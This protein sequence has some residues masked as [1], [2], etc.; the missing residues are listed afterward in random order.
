MN[1]LRKRLFLSDDLKSIYDTQLFKSTPITIIWFDENIDEDLNDQLQNIHDHIFI[2]TD[3]STF[4]DYIQTMV[5]EAI[6]VLSGA[7]S[8]T[9]IPIIHDNKQ[10]NS[11]YI[12]CIQ[13]S[14]YKYLCDIYSKIDSIHTEYNLL[15]ESLEKN[16][17]LIMKQQISLNLFDQS[18]QSTQDLTRESSEFLWY[19]LLREYIMKMI[20]T[21]DTKKI[22]LEKFRLYYRTNKPY[23]S[24]IDE[25]EQTYTTNDAIKWY[26]KGTFLFK[27]VNQALRTQDIEALLAVRYYVVDLCKCLKE[28]C[29]NFRDYYEDVIQVYRGQT[30]SDLE[31]DRLKNSIGQLISTNGF[32]STTRSLDIA[33][34]FATNTIFIINVKTQLEGVVFADVRFHS[35]TPHEE[36]ILFDLGTIF[37]IL[38][39]E[40]DD[41]KKLY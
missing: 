40:Y 28:E 8:Q 18:G 7:I 31:L 15:F 24:K 14:K 9:I 2:T 4:L 6:V 39:V 35:E 34:L 5:N 3:R 22:M 20:Q 12:F 32:L 11:I 36:E 38:E 26:T 37:K 13:D 25:F 30:L 1:C 16:I 29:E 33:S 21:N 19:Q 41:S 17:E 27:I 23:L 10:I